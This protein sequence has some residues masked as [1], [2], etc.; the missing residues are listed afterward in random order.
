LNH[1]E[2]P[3]CPEAIFLIGKGKY[4]GQGAK[5]L[6]PSETC[7]IIIY[8]DISYG[9]LNHHL[10]PPPPAHSQSGLADVF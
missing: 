8:S 5:P 1:L 9:T 6:S 2:F 10:I 4:A 7:R 3:H